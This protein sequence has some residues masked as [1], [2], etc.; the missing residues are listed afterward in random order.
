MICKTSEKLSLKGEGR[1]VSCPCPSPIPAGQNLDI[2]YHSISH[3]R[4][5]PGDGRTKSKPPQQL[6]SWNQK[7]TRPASTPAPLK[8]SLQP[9]TKLIFFQKKKKNHV[10]SKSWKPFSLLPNAPWIKYKALSTGSYDV[11]SDLLC[12]HSPDSA[13]CLPSCSQ[14]SCLIL[15]HTLSRQGWE[16]I[17]SSDGH[18]LSLLSWLNLTPQLTWWHG[19]LL[20]CKGAE[21][22]LGTVNTLSGPKKIT[23]YF[24]CLCKVPHCSHIKIR[25]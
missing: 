9:A 2:T 3:L 12:P 1:S 10:I 4:P 7:I 6:D 15:L 16:H 21:G 17:P 11:T 24:S 18:Y 20:R 13:H 25:W 22:L 14:A 5:C 8:T 19:T 23:S